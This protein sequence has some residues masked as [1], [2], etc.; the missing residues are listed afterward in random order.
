M[1]DFDELLTSIGI[2]VTSTTTR[3]P[4]KEEFEVHLP[5]PQPAPQPEEP[6]D[7]TISDDE[8]NEILSANGISITGKYQEPSEEDYEEDQEEELDEDENVSQTEAPP[9]T[10]EEWEETVDEIVTAVRTIHEET[11]EEVDDRVPEESEQDP[12]MVERNSPTLLVDESTSRFSG[13]EWYSEI[14]KQRIILAGLG[15]IGSTTALQLA[16]MAPATMVLYDDDH[17]EPA[18]MSGQLYSSN[19]QGMRKVN[20][21]TIMLS[22]Y[23]SAKNIIAID[24]KFT[25]ESEAGDIMIC[26]FDNMAARRTFFNAW[27]K[28]LEG[29]TEEERAKCLFIDGRLS[30]NLL[31][32]LCMTGNDDY[33]MRRYRKEFLFHD[34]EALETVC[35]M[36]QTTYLAFMIGSIITNLFTNFVAN[37]LNPIIPYS[38]PFFTEYNAQHMLLK[39]EK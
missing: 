29:K 6:V 34:N 5:E 26:G 3:K 15:G 13:A 22:Q 16:R 18:N 27:R 33:Y 24:E 10:E 39:M 21:L 35:S 25:E 32:V 38:L 12:R 1:N 36:K 4:V 14:Q 28:H 23:T 11:R 20:A 37:L 2:D 30:I 7:A 8:F 31:Q 9:F 17:V 19:D